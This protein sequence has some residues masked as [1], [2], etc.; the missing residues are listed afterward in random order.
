[1]FTVSICVQV[2]LAMEQVRNVLL[3]PLSLFHTSGDIPLGKWDMVHIIYYAQ[4]VYT[5]ACVCLH[6]YVCT[7]THVHGCVYV[8][9]CGICTHCAYITEWTEYFNL[10]KLTHAF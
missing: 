2:C 1:M 8:C 10:G 7:L 6:V 5:C 9:V 3:L 4:Y